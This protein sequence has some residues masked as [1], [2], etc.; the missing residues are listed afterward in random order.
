MLFFFPLRDEKQ[1]LSGCPKLHQNKLQGQ[2]V[3]HVPNM[4]KI[5][6]KPCDDLLDQ[7]FF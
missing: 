2:G 5:K 7:S 6:V 3:Q 1:L 4:K